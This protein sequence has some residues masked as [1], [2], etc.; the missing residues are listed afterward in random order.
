VKTIIQ[1]IGPLYGEVVNGSVFGQPNGSIARPSQNTP[2]SVS[3]SG[4]SATLTLTGTAVGGTISKYA[5]AGV[6]MEIQGIDSVSFVKADCYNS[7]GVAIANVQ[8]DVIAVPA[9]LIGGTDKQPSDGDELS[10]IVQLIDSYGSVIA[11]SNTLT[12]AAVIPE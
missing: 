12:I 11:T 9:Q 4:N 5:L 7:G 3:I 2:A 1:T 6:S 8:S 10:L